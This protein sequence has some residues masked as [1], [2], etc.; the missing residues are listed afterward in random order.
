MFVMLQGLMGAFCVRIPFV[1][2]MSGREGV[3]L[4][5][6]GLGTPAASTVQ[7]TLCLVMYFV[8]GRRTKQFRKE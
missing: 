1:Y 3:T 8:V 7:I 2:L 6:I 4:F 5:H